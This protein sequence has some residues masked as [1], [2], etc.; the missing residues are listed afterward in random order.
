MI[1]DSNEFAPDV[2]RHMLEQL[3]VCVHWSMPKRAGLL[4]GI[5]HIIEPNQCKVLECPG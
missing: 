3:E 2:V 5:G 4:C 1:E